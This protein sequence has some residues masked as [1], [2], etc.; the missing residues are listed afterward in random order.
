MAVHTQHNAAVGGD[1]LLR[2]DEAL[3]GASA[4]EPRLEPEKLID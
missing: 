3:L 1:R 2:L 4:K